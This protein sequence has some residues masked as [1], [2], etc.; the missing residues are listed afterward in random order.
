MS[1]TV[2]EPS[3]DRPPAEIE[4]TPEMIECG[5]EVIL[6]AYGGLDLRPCPSVVAERV[7]LA[8]RRLACAKL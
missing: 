2:E 8:M 5:E 1:D 6:S 7:Y 3:R 4:V